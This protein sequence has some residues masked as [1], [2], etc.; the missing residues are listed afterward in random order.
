MEAQRA[1]ME[2]TAPRFPNMK[3]D[4]PE[5]PQLTKMRAF[6]RQQHIQRSIEAGL[7]REEAEAHAAHDLE[8]RDDG[9]K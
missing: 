7:S 3:K 8:D 1:S 2:E 4:E 9:Q 6:D 5:F